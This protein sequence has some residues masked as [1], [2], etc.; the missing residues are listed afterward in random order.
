ML[1]PYTY[2]SLSLYEH[3]S[4]NKDENSGELNLRCNDESAVN[5]HGRC[6][7]RAN[8]IYPS[9]DDSVSKANKGPLNSNSYLARI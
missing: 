6:S 5:Q 9:L 2:F 1:F 4:N 3:I 7:S 8:F